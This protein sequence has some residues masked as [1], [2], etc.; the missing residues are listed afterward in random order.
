MLPCGSTLLAQCT[1]IYRRIIIIPSSVSRSASVELRALSTSVISDFEGRSARPSWTF[2]SS[3]V[4]APC[5]HHITSQN[6]MII[7]NDAVFLNEMLL[8]ID[9][10]S[11][12]CLGKTI[13]LKDR[14]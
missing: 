9:A 14:V 13:C 2:R 7:H 12:A 6:K 3:A 11:R 1:D 5:Q 8:T 10:L 4:M